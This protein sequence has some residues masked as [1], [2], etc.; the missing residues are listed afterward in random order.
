ML[1]QH[2]EQGHVQLGGSRITV[3]GQHGEQGHGHLLRQHGWTGSRT[4]NSVGPT[5]WAVSRP[6]DGGNIVSRVTDY[7]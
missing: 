7:C 6:S 5:R 2:G 1:G 3:L 4:D